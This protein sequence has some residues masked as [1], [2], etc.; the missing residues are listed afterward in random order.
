[1]DSDQFLPIWTVA[2]IE[3]IK[4]IITTDPYLILEILWSSPM[5]QV[6]KKGEKERPSH[7]GCILI[8][9]EI[10]DTTPVEEVKALFKNENCFVE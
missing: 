6:D 4:I 1:M 2:N 3:E 7:K 5:V 9:R 8:L 10:P